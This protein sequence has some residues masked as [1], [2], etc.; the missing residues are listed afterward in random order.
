MSAAT[1]GMIDLF[2]RGAER[3][4]NAFH[5][6]IKLEFALCTDRPDA[7]SPIAMSEMTHK[8]HQHRRQTLDALVE[9]LGT[10]TANV[11]EQADIAT[12][13]IDKVR[14]GAQTLRLMDLRSV[15]VGRKL[16]D[17][18]TIDVN[19]VIGNLRVLQ[20][21]AMMTSLRMGVSPMLGFNMVKDGALGKLN[22]VRLDRA[23]RKWD[24]VVYTHAVFRGGLVWT[25]VEQFC[26]AL[27]ANG[28]DLAFV[29]GD[30]GPITFSITDT[31]P[32][33]A[34]MDEIAERYFHPNA[35]RLLSLA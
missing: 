34:S 17:G 5:A 33:H 30:E 27:T 18:L 24:S 15:D 22:L 10:A 28:I 9:L 11:A 1:I 8:L 20:T 29:E 12:E 3:I 7:H 2:A 23:G 32:G 16:M 35:S 21:K 19:T 25:Y 14:H 31:T 26:L 13:S 6:R 4:H